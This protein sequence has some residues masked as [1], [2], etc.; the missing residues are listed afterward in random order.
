MV[1]LR[2]ELEKL[3]KVVLLMWFNTLLEGL[4]RDGYMWLSLDAVEVLINEE[5]MKYDDSESLPKISGLANRI[6]SKSTLSC[7][8]TSDLRH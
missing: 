4:L 5:M 8:S 7:F 2:N 6:S 3:I 1:I